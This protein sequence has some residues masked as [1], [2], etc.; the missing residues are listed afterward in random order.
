MVFIQPKEKK[1]VVF[2]LCLVGSF[3]AGGILGYL[4]NY[5]TKGTF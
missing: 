3:L 4:I 2:I 1:P 5:L